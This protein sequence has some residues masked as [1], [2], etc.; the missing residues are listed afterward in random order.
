MRSP[1]DLPDFPDFSDQVDA[2]R[3]SR[4]GYE[5]ALQNLLRDLHAAGRPRNAVPPSLNR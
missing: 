4:A 2:V 5:A 3:R 1:H